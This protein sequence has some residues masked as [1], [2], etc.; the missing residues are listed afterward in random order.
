MDVKRIAIFAS[1]SGS[2]AQNIIEYFADNKNIIVDSVWTNNPSAY[3]LERAKKCGV[4]SFIFSREEFKS[5]LFVVEK[6]KNRNINLIVLAGFLWL[7]PSNLIQN[8]RIIN[9][10]PALLPTYGGKGMYGMN[11]HQAVVENKE[12]ESG[13]SIHFVNEKYDEGEIIFQAVCPVLPSDSPEDVAEKVHQL[14]YKHFPEV[15]EKVL[16]NTSN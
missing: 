6:L 14:E 8:F 11:V 15:I 1:G 16:I 2:N 12:I 9:I 13:I 7:I 5:T 4:D 10:H 3:V